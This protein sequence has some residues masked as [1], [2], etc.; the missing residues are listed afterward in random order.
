MEFLLLLLAA[1]AILAALVIS[2]FS[3]GLSRRYHPVVGT[4]L[5]QLVHF[6]RLYDYHTEL[7]HRHKSF[8]ILITPFKSIIYTSDPALVEHVL[9]SSF[10]NYGKGQRNYENLK[11]LLGD[12][13]FVVDGSKWRHQRKLFSYEFSTRSLREHSGAVFKKNA[14]KLAAAV[15]KSAVNSHQAIEMQDYF[16]KSAMDSI[17]EIAFGTELNYLQGSSE[18]NSRFITALDDANMQINKRYT[19]P[20]WKL[21]KIFNIGTEAALIENVKVVDDY[22]YKLIHTK[23]VKMSSTRQTNETTVEKEDIL[24]RFLRESERDPEN[25]SIQY[26]RDI[27]LNFVVAGKDTTGG[28]LA[29]FLYMLCK[30]PSVQEK[31]ALEIKQAVRADEDARFQDFAANITEE[32]LE[33]MQYLHA[34]LNETLRLYPALPLDP[35]VCFSDDKLP[36]GFDIRKGEIIVYQPYC[37]GRMKYLWGEDA[38]DF[39]PERWLDENGVICL[40][41][42]FKFTAF[43]AGPRICLGKEFAYR[44]MKIFSTVLLR[45]FRFQLR[46]EKESINYRM[47][48]TLM[49]DQGI[50]LR[51]FER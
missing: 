19:N 20:F 33:K 18:E 21:M 47:N 14:A 38:E 32:S 42:P 41:N 23:V 22:V 8:R 7:S 40:E 37:M 12:G 39:R 51:V 48:L 24:S 45:F 1:G 17:F 26:L 3:T 6:R 50:Y 27:V 29:W 2:R 30:H 43:Q 16:F 15:S 9:R 44:Q 28:T 36:D 46:D 13:I 10:H 35:K 25:M 11:D 5:H 49:V 31:I 4:F 34:T